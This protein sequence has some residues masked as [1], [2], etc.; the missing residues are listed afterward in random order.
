MRMHG[1]LRLT[2]RAAGEMQQCRRRRLGWTN[3][4]VFVC[5]AERPCKIARPV[6]KS[7]SRSVNDQ[8]RLQTAFTKLTAEEVWLR[9]FAPKKTLSH[10]AVVRFTQ[11]DYDR[12]MC[13]ILTE[14]GRPR[15][16][17]IFGVANL[18]A[19]PD[20]RSAEY[21]IV[22]RHDVVGL[23]L[24]IALM[25]RIIDYARYR[26]IKEI[27]GDVLEENRPMLKLCK[28]LGFSQSRVP[29]DPGVTRVTPKL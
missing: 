1:P 8:P 23:G 5:F 21:A 10:F 27:L 6:R 2:R 26:G 22:V 18:I 14:P 25:R 9:F 29:D 4:V 11:I 16:T 3:L 28:I 12:D 7:Y 15:Q 24:G 17:E 13:L 20:N 19:D